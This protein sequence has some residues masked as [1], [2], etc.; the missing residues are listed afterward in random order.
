MDDLLR[1][2]LTES[3]ENLQRLDQEIVELEQRPKDAALLNRVFRTMHTIKGTCGFIGLARLE[4]VAHSAEGVLSRL[5]EGE[6]QISPALISDIL[7]ATEVI[8]VILESLERTQLEPVGDDSDL[9]KRLD[10][11]LAAD[12][13]VT[14]GTNEF[15]IAAA[16]ATRAEPCSDAT[17]RVESRMECNELADS[18]LRVNVQLLD[19]LMNLVGELVLGR[20]QLNQLAMQDEASVFAKPV[21]H[22]NRVTT[23]LQDAVM[24]T[25]MQPIGTAW[26]KLPRL[27]RELGQ[28]SGKMIALEM[29]GQDT[30]L[31]RQI[32]QAIGDPL[33]HM[34][35]N[36]AD[37]GIETPE[38]RRAAGKSEC[39]TIQLN[40]FHEGGHVIL[41]ITDDGAGLDI[42]RVSRK[43]VERGLVKA[44]AIGTLTEAQILRFVFEPGFSTAERITNVSGRGVGMDVVRSSIEK[45]GGTVELLSAK[46]KGTTVRI[47]IPLTL[48]IVSALL[49]GVANEVFAIPQIGVIELVRVSEEQRE[50]IEILHGAKYFRL[51]ES[52]LPL[53]SLASTLKLEPLKEAAEYNIIVCQLGDT[54]FGMTV[55]EVFDT[56]E[57]VVKPVGR[58]VKHLANYAGCTILGDG[59]VIMILDTTGVGNAGLELSGNAHGANAAATA[60]TRDERATAQLE[61]VLV[62]D[63][64]YEAMQ[65]VPL[66]RI[67][68]LEEIPATDIAY[69]DGRYLVEYR[70]TLLPL[71]PVN[72]AMDVRGKTMRPVLV[73]SAEGRSVG[74]AVEEIRDIV[75]ER[76]HIEGTG[77]R[78]GVRGVCTIAGR[79]SEVI[80][81][82]HFVRL[83]HTWDS[84][85]AASVTLNE[86]SPRNTGA[87]NSGSVV[88]Q[89]N[90]IEGMAA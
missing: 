8:R 40:A 76:L 89:G 3:T 25:R 71:V 32:L 78:P 84:G 2:F 22:L 31:D 39:G 54:R 66:S 86:L 24:R 37:H 43:A 57:I 10:A 50:K 62:F 6:I 45:I 18:S 81:P 75:E 58:L 16:S 26:S 34:V 82:D 15:P 13:N 79:I 52:L 80:D 36:S 14:A 72:P 49:V 28:A 59:R 51:R 67:A 20:N 56:Q 1:E 88:H 11:W 30:E 68:R 87:P 42:E 19:K 60:D 47:K 17:M 77:H 44:E 74:L 33:T 23:D 35:R 73:L 27:V 65:A 5:R 63:G 70:G 61:S 90:V 9:L 53:V 12:V 55:D 38:S 41:E 48:A 85:T 64:G 46:G 69:A 4:T 83:A 21:Q 7:A 29:Y